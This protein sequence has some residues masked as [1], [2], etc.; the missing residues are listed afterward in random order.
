[1][2]MNPVY[3]WKPENFPNPEA[4]LPESL[5]AAWEL[6]DQWS[7]QAPPEGSDLSP[8][9]E[10]A[11]YIA[12]AARSDSASEAFKQ[13]YQDVE[14]WLP[15]RAALYAMPELSENY[16]E[17]MPILDDHSQSLGLVLYDSN[18]KLILPDGREFPDE[19][20]FA[21]I[22]DW[23]KQ[24]KEA[25]R[26]WRQEN[27]GL[28]EKLKDFY[29]YL[30]PKTDELMGRYGFA[31]APQFYRPEGLPK[32]SKKP[33][34]DV[35]IYAK[36]MQYGWQIIYIGMYD[37][38]NDGD[39]NIL[40]I[41]SL[42]DEQVQQI[43]WYE[44]DNMRPYEKQNNIKKWA[45]VGRVNVEYYLDDAWMENQQFKTETEIEELLIHIESHLKEVSFIYNY[46][47]VD[48]FYDMKTVT[49]EEHNVGKGL[50]PYDYFPLRLV[51]LYL[52][53]KQNLRQVV[54][55]WLSADDAY[56]YNKEV[57]K[58]RLMKTLNHLENRPLEER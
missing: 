49:A 39:Y 18:G 12:E 44:L 33:E 51:V 10:L 2:S 43:Y 47:D 31:Y 7:E 52:N 27:R 24:E 56:Y 45:A 16:I 42:S 36:P 1:M 50:F 23:L 48:K 20:F 55:D 37:I 11:G 15:K 57:A 46:N 14:N 53:G 5:E 4:M 29:A 6:T 35:M 17:I 3:L 19:S 9:T 54:E 26:K 28:P 8:F 21:G 22:T 30:R 38:Y 58:K 13:T 32:K 34:P 40:V 41:W 25:E